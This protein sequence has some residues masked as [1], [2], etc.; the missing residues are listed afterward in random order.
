M[1]KYKIG[2]LDET[3]E[4]ANGVKDCILLPSMQLYHISKVS[5]VRLQEFN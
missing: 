5:C 4:V 3:Q 2:G 1:L